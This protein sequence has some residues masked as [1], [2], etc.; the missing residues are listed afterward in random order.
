M[1]GF[2]LSVIKKTCLAKYGRIGNVQFWINSML[3]K[4]FTTWAYA[5]ISAK[6]SLEN[7]FYHE[8]CIMYIQ[9]TSL[10]GYSGEGSIMI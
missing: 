7:K 4:D 8:G 3:E 6:Y 1:D 2:K 10:L 9:Y 5:K